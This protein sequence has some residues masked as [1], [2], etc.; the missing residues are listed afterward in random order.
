LNGSRLIRQEGEYR[1]ERTLSDEEALVAYRD[2]F[3]MVLDRLPS[4]PAPA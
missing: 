1:T 3:G 4:T 2:L